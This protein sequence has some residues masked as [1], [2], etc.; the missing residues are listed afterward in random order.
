M[1]LLIEYYNSDNASRNKEYI[2]CIEKNLS[3][4]FINKIHVFIDDPNTEL[5]I[6]SDKLNIIRV[7]KRNTYSDFFNYANFNLQGKKVILANTD[8]FFDET[9][10]ELENFKF[11]N[12][13][14]A[15]T[16][17]DYNTI[18]KKSDLY[19]V[20]MS[21]DSWVFETPIHVS[22]AD[23]CLG[24]PG[25]DNRISYLLHDSGY[26]VRNP[27]MQIKSHH[28]H[29]SKYRTYTTA[30][31]I[32]GWYMTLLPSNNINASTFKRIIENF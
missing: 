30:D 18:T 13:V 14:L 26:D 9:L 15:L 16:R 22:G 31:T 32:A 12:I 4:K 28:V 29:D 17:W 24:K 6:K 10:G 21:Q 20:D 5:N 8:I 25:C 11:D 1:E 7:N 2:S 3:N 27:S 19:Y 23:F